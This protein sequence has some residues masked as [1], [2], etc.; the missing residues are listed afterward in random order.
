MLVSGAFAS[1]PK[2]TITFAM[3]VCLSV[4]QA[5]WNNSAPTGQVVMKFGIWAFFEN[6][7]KIQVSLTSEKN[8][9]HF[10]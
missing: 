2:A 3:S 10:K 7:G 9:G 6:V 8:N 5:A 1:L 4:S